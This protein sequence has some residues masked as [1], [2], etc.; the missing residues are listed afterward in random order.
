MIGPAQR[1][2]I[3]LFAGCGGLS[4]GAQWAGFTP[5]FAIEKSDM[6]S[7]T[8]FH[9][10][11]AGGDFGWVE[12]LGLSGRGDFTAAA[13]A[14]IIVG[15]ITKVVQDKRFMAHARDLEPD[16]VAGGPPCQGFSMAGRR[17]YDDE[18]NKL[19]WAFLDFVG[20]TSPKAVV[21]ENVVGINRAFK[22]SGGGADTPFAQLTKALEQTGR[23]YVVQP[24]EVNARHFG[25][26]QS[27]PRMMLLAIRSDL[28][29]GR[30]RVSDD[31]WRSIDA[32]EGRAPL[33]D[34]APAVM[35]V[36]G[37][38]GEQ[39][40]AVQAIDDLGPL[41]REA[42]PAYTLALDDVDGY[43]AVA[44]FGY[45]MR[46]HDESRTPPVPFNHNPRNHT[47]RVTERFLA[48]HWLEELGIHPARVMGIGAA[49]DDGDEAKREVKAEL[50]GNV[51]LPPAAKYAGLG[52]EGEDFADV[53]VRLTTKK[54]S[55]RVVPAH[56]P[57][58]TV[59]TLPDDYIHPREPR[60]MTVRELARFQS[61]PDWFEFKSK[62]TTGSHRRKVEVPQYSQVGNAVPPLMARAVTSTL[63]SALEEIGA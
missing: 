20:H 57:A 22:R 36:Q 9:N 33:T 7:E 39:Y 18:R 51:G 26:P 16:L 29:A 4:L 40:S 15:D 46:T 50:G 55:Q 41:D 2:M 1:T 31:I 35:R 27:R 12:A 14:G 54:H 23:G 13:Q 30:L 43:E 52:C 63:L 3:D 21:V 61:F 38:P 19:P 34:L 60:I 44:P 24:V 53:I 11:H 48:Y 58:P 62:E 42:G 6:A 32:W 5:S 47:A 37:E 10:F 17:N 49:I 25:V 28:A 56:S 45:L 8:Y 59:V